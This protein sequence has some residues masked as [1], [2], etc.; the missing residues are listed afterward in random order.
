[1]RQIIWSDVVA[2]PGCGNETT[3]AETRVRYEPLRF[4][5]TFTCACGHTGSPDDWPR[6]LE[7]V[8]D[9]WTGDDDHTP[10]S[11]AME[12]VRHVDVRQLEPGRGRR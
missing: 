4:D 7:D 2:C 10:Q 11:R 1:M 6:V 5:D 3:Y 12:G 8:L 9:P